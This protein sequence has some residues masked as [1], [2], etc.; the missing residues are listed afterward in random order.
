MNRIEII[1]FINENVLPTAEIELSDWH[2]FGKDIMWIIIKG[3]SKWRHGK[4]LDIEMDAKILDGNLY[5]NGDFVV[6][7]AP[8]LRRPKY[9]E[10]AYYWEGRCLARAG[11]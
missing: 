2:D 1:N 4:P 8:K 3:F 9:D 5:I 7:V 10:E 11:L 6:R